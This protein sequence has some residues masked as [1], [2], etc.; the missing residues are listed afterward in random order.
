MSATILGGGYSYEVTCVC[1]HATTFHAEVEGGSAYTVTFSFPIPTAQHE[2]LLVTTSI[3]SSPW[4]GRWRVIHST[5][6]HFVSDL[7]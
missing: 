6:Y 7:D 3:H 1:S 2:A 5:E 4:V